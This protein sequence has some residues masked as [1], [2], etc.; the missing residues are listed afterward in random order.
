MQIHLSPPGSFASIAI[1]NRTG[2]PGV[3]SVVLAQT[4]KCHSPPVFWTTALQGAHAILDPALARPTA[5]CP[6]ARSGL[7]GGSV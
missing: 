3:R 4:S 1:Q 5:P 2:G 7:S 6:Q